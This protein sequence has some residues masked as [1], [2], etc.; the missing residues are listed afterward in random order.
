[1]VLA[2]REYKQV[3]KRSNLIGK[4][5]IIATNKLGIYCFIFKKSTV[6]CENNECFL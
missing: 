2:E 5:P 4:S 3:F 1:M 6:F